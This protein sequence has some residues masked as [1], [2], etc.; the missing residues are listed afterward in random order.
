METAETLFLSLSIPDSDPSRAAKLKIAD[1]A[2]GFKIIDMVGGGI[3]DDESN[4][5]DEIDWKGDFVWLMCAG[6][7]E[8]LRFELA[9]T[10]DQ[11]EPELQ[12]TFQGIELKHGASDLRRHLAQ[13]DLWP[14]YRLRAVVILQQR[15]F[16]QLQLLYSTQEDVEALPHGDAADVRSFPYASALK[17]RRL[18]FEL[19]EKAYGDFERQVSLPPSFSPACLVTSFVQLWMQDVIFMLFQRDAVWPKPRLQA[20]RA[21]TFDNQY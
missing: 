9:R 11:D 8:G 19:L 2:P 16:D 20:V 13:S 17:L 15:V 14:V 3:V 7:E 18:E 4:T 10:V 1:C 12:A 5:E 6:E 21:R